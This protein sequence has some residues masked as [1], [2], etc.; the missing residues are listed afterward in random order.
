M[1]TS[2]GRQDVSAV[3]KA[4][5]DRLP[6][7]TSTHKRWMVLLAFF[8]LFDTLDAAMLGYTAPALRAEWG[9]SLS[10]IGAL[11]SITFA[12][13]MIGAVLGGRLADRVGRRRIILGSVVFYSVFSVAAACSPNVG[14]LGVS[15]I[16]TG[17]G[18]QAMTGVL[19]VFVSEMYPKH[20][21]GRYQAILLGLG[22][23]GIP[24]V[25]GISSLLIPLGHGMWRWVFVIGSLGAIG[26]LLGLRILPES[27]RWQADNGRGAEAELLIAK[28]EQEARDK[29]GTEL[30]QPVVAAPV[31]PG[32][33]RDL[34]TRRY[35]GRLVVLSVCMICFILINYGFNGWVATL[36]VERGIEQKSALRIAFVISVASVPGSF[37]AYP[38]I[39]RLERRVVGAGS[40]V[41]V[42]IFLV[43][44]AV[45][46]DTTLLVVSGF[47]LTAFSYV[48]LSVL[49]TYAP[50]IFPT[51]L[52]GLGAGVGN[53]IGRVAG[54]AQGFIVAGIY[55][56]FG[57]TPVFGYMAACALIF[58]VALGFFGRKT[59][60]RSLEEV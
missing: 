31:A 32:E 23:I 35:L 56:A 46:R 33:L 38:V 14:F 21:R 8:F 36:L 59:S 19:L 20:L 29:T 39:D 37:L 7:A 4:R 22:C 5:I 9:L 30:P 6:V 2:T 40:M 55:G 53:G 57:F 1:T 45:A 12:G 16:L 24:V 41:A 17:V 27:V 52:R 44:F 26:A 11:S 15:R 25:S 3:L 18:L 28:L 54:L 51:N 48:A 42:A 50:E 60:N 34:F 13:M 43:V 58:A 47:L 10:A 49:Y